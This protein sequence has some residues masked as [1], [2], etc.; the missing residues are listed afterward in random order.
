[1]ARKTPIP[2]FYPHT[3]VGF[4]GMLNTGA[5]FPEIWTCG[6]RVIDVSTGGLPLADA[7]AYAD[8]IQ[9]PLK[10]WFQFQPGGAGQQGFPTTS[11]LEWLK[12]NNILPNGKYADPVTHQHLYAP[13]GVGKV[14]PTDVTNY[15]VDII[16]LVCSWTT[17]YK[18]AKAGKGRIYLPNYHVATKHP[19]GM[20]AQSGYT[21]YWVTTAQKLLDVLR[22]SGGAHQATPI[23]CSTTGEHHTI[24]GVRVG[25]TLDVQRK[26]KSAVPEMYA[27]GP[28]PT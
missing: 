1:M 16:S 9:T 13:I 26:R 20:E 25:S 8:E 3:Y 2:T 12:V 27:S 17:D 19:G 4:G 24:T 6:V 7:Q 21:G 15:N 14:G 22:N 18:R 28:W 23:I 10:A 5:D 11:T